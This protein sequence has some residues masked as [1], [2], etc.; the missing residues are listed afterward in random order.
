[1]HGA[2][3]QAFGFHRRGQLTQELGGEPATGHAADAVDE[4]VGLGAQLA[5]GVDV[6][7]PAALVADLGLHG[8][9]FKLASAFNVNDQAQAGQTTASEV[10]VDARELG[11]GAALEKG[12]AV[13][14]LEEQLR[15]RGTV[16]AAQRR[17]QAFG[18][19]CQDFFITDSLG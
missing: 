19:L 16:R 3:A 4:R 9:L 11:L 2:L 7:P 13:G 5:T 1:M 12:G 10:V 14:V 15:D 6:L 17:L 18:G 8:Y